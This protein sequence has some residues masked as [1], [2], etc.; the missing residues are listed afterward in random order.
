[1]ILGSN[2]EFTC[3]KDLEEFGNIISLM[4]T[5]VLLLAERAMNCPKLV[6]LYEARRGGLKTSTKGIKFL[7]DRHT[8]R[9]YLL[10]LYLP[11]LEIYQGCFSPEIE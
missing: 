8:C 6:L 5:L 1:M 7:E 11:R 10:Y 3:V 4:S 2:S 9:P